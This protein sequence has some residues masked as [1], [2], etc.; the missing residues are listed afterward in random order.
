MG[1]DMKNIEFLNQ[2]IDSYMEY[3]KKEY[4]NSV[5]VGDKIA[6]IESAVNISKTL[7]Q[8]ESSILV[9]GTK[10]HDIG[11]FKQYDILGNFND[12][13]VSHN[14]IGEDVIEQLI[15]AKELP[16]SNELD[17]IR[18]VIQYHG[19]EHLIPN[20]KYLPKEVIELVKKVSLIDIIENSCIGAL[21]YLQRER[22]EDAKG[23]AKDNPNLD[24]KSVSPF[25]FQE[26][27]SGRSWDKNVYNKTYADYTLFA[28]SL[29]IKCLR[30]EYHDFCKGV[31]AQKCFNYS[32][33]IS[34]YHAVLKDMI[35]PQKVDIVMST[36]LYYYNN[37]VPY[38]MTE[39]KGLKK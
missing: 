21:N 38:E 27:I 25:V 31:L 11:R 6:H 16:S 8:N 36:I 7:D 26:F 28:V 24:M 4:S 22:D 1:L 9:L 29:L 33:A 18:L 12:R 20:A 23:Y 17:A 15:S 35:E 2:Y 3:V 37:Y 10:Y 13:I 39:K 30:S 32:D 14:S 34:G 19:K 5:A